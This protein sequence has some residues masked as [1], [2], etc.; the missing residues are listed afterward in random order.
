[1]SSF[2]NVVEKADLNWKIQISNTS[3]IV[4]GATSSEGFSSFT[5]VSVVSTSRF[6]DIRYVFCKET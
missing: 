3:G 1:M 4:V 2:G 5:D 6:T